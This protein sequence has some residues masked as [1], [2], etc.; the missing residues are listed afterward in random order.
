M[1]ANLALVQ[2]EEVTRTFPLDHSA[3]RALDGAS[4]SVAAGEFVAIA[5]PSG[6]GKIDTA[7]PDRLHRQAD[8]GADCY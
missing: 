3:V 2:V 5:G 7:E 8:F 6:S 1:N 4:L